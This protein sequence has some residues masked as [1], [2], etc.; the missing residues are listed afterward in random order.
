MGTTAMTD[1]AINSAHCAPWSWL[2][3]PRFPFTASPPFA[4]EVQGEGEAGMVRFGQNG[5]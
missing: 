1:A 2:N 5:L 3:R 4:D